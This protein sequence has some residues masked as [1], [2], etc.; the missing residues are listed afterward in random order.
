MQFIDVDM[1]AF[2]LVNLLGRNVVILSK[3]IGFNVPCQSKLIHLLDFTSIEKIPLI[4]R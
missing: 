1:K 4:F 2:A 3:S